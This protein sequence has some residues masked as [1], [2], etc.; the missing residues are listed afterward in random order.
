M[1]ASYQLVRKIVD[2]TF[3]V[4]HLH[5]YTLSIQVSE[6]YFRFCVID[7]KRNRC[8]LIEDYNFS[9]HFNIEELIQTLEFLYDDHHVLQAG[10]WKTVRLSIKNLKFSLVPYALFDEKSMHNYLAINTTFTE[11]D[12]IYYFK[13][14]SN[15]AVN[16]FAA[17]SKL[18]E[19]FKRK[20]PQ[21]NVELLHHT[22]LMIEGA[23]NNQQSKSEKQ[24]YIN[25][26]NKFFTIIVKKKGSLEFCNNFAYQTPN[27]FLYFVLFVYDQ[28][29][30][31]P[32]N[33]PLILAGNISKNSELYLRL[34]KYIRMIQ[35]G[36]KP[37]YMSFGYKFDE[38]GD[39]E[40]FELYSSY[41]C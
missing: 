38:I 21:K 40:Y 28:L 30:L 39:H 9:K 13:H 17:E 25:V 6:E 36:N 16:V 41:L 1:N 12:G 29:G 8:L 3:E 14:G 18:I 5:H 22:S 35:F 34:Y 31:N 4:D 23:L 10:F 27:D 11:G 26:E 19:W 32:E 20:Y 33:V 7:T 15:D 37:S 24:V 2:D